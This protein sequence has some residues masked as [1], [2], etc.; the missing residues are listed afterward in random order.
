MQPFS[1]P[2]HPPRARRPTGGPEQSPKDRTTGR[3]HAMAKYKLIVLINAI[4]GRE[5]E[6][7]DWFTNQHM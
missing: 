3:L 2:P 1:R 6:F 7:N 4:E 5:D